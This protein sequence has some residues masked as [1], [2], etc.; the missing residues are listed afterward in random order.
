M[1]FAWTLRTSTYHWAFLTH[2]KPPSLTPL[3][4][5]SPVYL[6]AEKLEG[7]F[8]TMLSFLIRY[9]SPDATASKETHWCCEVSPKGWWC[10]GA[11]LTQIH[12]PNLC[13]TGQSIVQQGISS[14]E[15]SVDKVDQPSLISQGGKTGV[16]R[17]SHLCIA[18][19]GTGQSWKWKLSL[20]NPA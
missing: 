11:L 4:G 16:R 14:K 12:Q 2:Q 9:G 20:F 6:M 10:K 8:Y 1:L 19:A 15:Q 7:F 18:I 5:Q 13:N 3:I 17:L